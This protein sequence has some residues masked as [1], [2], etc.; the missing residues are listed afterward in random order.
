MRPTS[1][2]LTN[3]RPYELRGYGQGYRLCGA[4][5][6][7]CEAFDGGLTLLHEGRVL[8]DEI[9]Q[10]GQPPIP[11]DHEKSVHLTVEQAQARQAQRPRWKPA[12]DHPW[13]RDSATTLPPDP[14]HDA[15][16]KRTFQLGS[17]GDI[18]E[19]G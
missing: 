11:L 13:R 18:C 5:I 6:T 2:S 4:R 15:P 9:L 1:A 14:Q 17:K 8:D 3:V 10:E 7:V 16:P 12:P 19:L